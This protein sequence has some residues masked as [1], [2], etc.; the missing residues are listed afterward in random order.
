[1]RISDWSSDVCSSDLRTVTRTLLPDFRVH[2]AGV[3]GAGLGHLRLIPG[4]QV[5]L[6]IS[7][8]LRAASL[9]A[10]VKMGAGVVSM[11]RRGGG[12]YLLATD[13]VGHP[14]IRSIDRGS[15]CGMAMVMGRRRVQADARFHEDGHPR[16]W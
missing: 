5:A 14:S 16:Q 6:G 1:M 2:R 8:E 13:R 4:R 7:H 12:I 11:M 9:R 15:A 10:E 3:D